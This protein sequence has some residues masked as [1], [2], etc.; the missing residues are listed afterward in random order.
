[1]NII[2][3]VHNDVGGGPLTELGAGSGVL[4]LPGHLNQ[5]PHYYEWLF[6]WRHARVQV[7]LAAGLA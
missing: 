7:F 5:S 3:A 4:Y 2:H 6:R 1:M